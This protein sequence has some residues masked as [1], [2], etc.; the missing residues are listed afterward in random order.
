MPA[1]LVS[2]PGIS[3]E[4]PDWYLASR[5]GEC[6]EIGTLRR[7]VPDLGEIGSPDEFVAH[8]RRK[9]HLVEVNVPAELD[10]NA[11]AVRVPE[12]ELALL[13]VRRELC[14]GF[15]RK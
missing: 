9:G 5:H 14:K 11:V 10:N 8:M 1:L 3:A 13:F 7:K 12:E 6:A 15:L 2:S 4:P